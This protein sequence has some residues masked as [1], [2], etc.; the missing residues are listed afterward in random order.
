MI[1]P[2]I[3]GPLIAAAFTLMVYSFFY[4]ENKAY[5]FAEHVFIG[6]AVAHGT[7]ISSKYVWDVALSPLITKGEAFWILPILVGLLFPFFFSKKYFWVYRIPIS[8]VV[9]TGVG[10]GMAGLIRSQFIDQ[11]VQTIAPVSP[12]ADI[13]SSGSHPINALL[14]AIGTLGTLLFFIFTR[15]QKGLLL[16]ASHIGRW[17]MM[18][19]FGAAFG[20]TVMARMS[21]LI[22]RMQ[23]LLDPS[24]IAW[25][26]IPVAIVVLAVVAFAE[27]S[28]GA[29]K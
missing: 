7:V 20:F 2:E 28:K 19:A 10:I 6:L 11:I 26:L 12:K 9:G 13:W 21:L 1:T 14:I 27:R 22:G 18:I 5:R 23:F 16:Y 25:Y 3:V 4:R 8:I 24:G 15:E 17:T 29:K